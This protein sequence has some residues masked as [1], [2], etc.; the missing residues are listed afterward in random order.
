MKHSALPGRFF[1]AGALLALAVPDASAQ[2]PKNPQEPKNLASNGSFENPAVEP[3][4]IQ[5]LVSAGAWTAEVGVLEIQN[6][7][8]STVAFAGE[9][10]LALD[11]WSVVAQT[12]STLPGRSYSLS[13][14]CSPRPGAAEAAFEVWFAG[15]LKETVV[16]PAGSPAVWSHRD[17][18]V[19]GTSTADRLEFRALTG[20]PA[21]VLID[22][23]CLLPYDSASS[24]QIL[25]NGSFEDDPRLPPGAAL[26]TPVYIG[27]SSGRHYDLMM[28]DLGNAGN[29]YDGKNVLH[30]RERR[31]VFQRVHVLPGQSYQLR[32]AYSPNPADDRARQF[33]VSFDGRLLE[34]ISVPL[35]STIAWTLKTYTVSSSRPLTSVEFKDLSGGEQGNLL[36]GVT[37]TGPVPEP[38]TAGQISSHSIFSRDGGIVLNPDAMFA[39]GITGLGDLDGDGIQ[40]LAIGSVGDDDGGSN[41]GAVWIAF[42]DADRTV[43]ASQKISELRGGLVADLKKDDGFG[44]ALAGIGDLDADG[45]PDLAVGANEDDTG[46][47]NAGS[48][49]VLFLTRQGTVRAQHKI[50]ALSGDVLDYAPVY[51]SN[52]GAAI[53][54]MGDIDGDGI[55][56][57]AVGSRYGD[58][59][60]TCFMQRDGTVRGSKNITYGTNGFTDTVTSVSDF[61]GMSCANMGD[62]DGDGIDDLLVGAFGRRINFQNYV[63]GQYL[64]LL[65]SDGSVKR[66]FYYATENMNTR[67]QTLGVNYNLGTACAGLGDVDGDGVLDLATGAQREGALSGLDREESTNQGAVYVLLLNSNGT[68]KTCQR[69]GDR[70]GGLDVRL[71]DGTRWGES[72]CALGDF[73]GNGLT[74]VAVGS[75]FVQGTGAVYMCEL[76]GGRT[77]LRASFGGAPLTGP[78][79]LTVQFADLSTGPVTAWSWEFGDGATSDLATPS[80]TYVASGTYTVRLTVHAADGGSDAQVFDDFVSVADDSLPPGVVKL[81]CGVNPPSSFRILSGSPRIG[82]SMTFGVDN[83]FGT[84]APGSVAVISGAWLPNPSFPCGALQPGRGMS[85]PQTPGEL[86]IATPVLWT[87][88]GAAWTAPGDPAAVVYPV[89]NNASLL[90]RT[91]YVQG[92]LLDGSSGAP[93]PIGFADG[94]ALT[95]GP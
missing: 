75:R 58:S 54:A 38:E 77:P 79:P 45:I 52:F 82:T 3:G 71:D 49:Y 85:A 90:G 4:G 59:V 86:L 30:I 50:T 47:Y 12:C 11:A 68:I 15:S 61:F 80:H 14:A 65:R 34:T 76:L 7:M 21:A 32:F 19:V 91:L 22:D 92:R 87:R 95:F 60:Q 66:W 48:V 1:L 13:F 62:F 8:G 9:Q 2:A 44:R 72:L 29:G 56:D 64:F 26:E 31:A 43:R 36:D 25:R 83:P 78:A 24:D 67:T 74:D 88:R 89:P 94:F 10:V 93:I 51:E 84:Q 37:L 40:D 28:H 41:A 35:S 33:T 46:A 6:H 39:R 81:G 42:M 53:A 16:V 27:W 70:A 18:P 5:R 69:I 55:Q 57:M 73:D 63:G 20:D 23:C 17:Y